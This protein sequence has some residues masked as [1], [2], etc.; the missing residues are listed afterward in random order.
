MR[1]EPEHLARAFLTDI[2]N[3]ADRAV[4][5]GRPIKQEFPAQSR[6]LSK[7][8]GQLTTHG[9][10]NS[11]FI[12]LRLAARENAVALHWID[13]SIGHLGHVELLDACGLARHLG[14]ERYESVVAR[15][16]VVLQDVASHP[17]VAELLAAWPARSNPGR[18]T[19][20]RAQDVRDALRVIEAASCLTDDIP[21]R[22]LSCQL[23]HDSKRVEA[24][25]N[26]V[27][28]LADSDPDA[29]VDEVL[30]QLGIIQFPQPLLIAGPCTITTRTGEQLRPQPYLGLAPTAL[31]SVETIGGYLL[32]VENLTTFNELAA[33]L[34]GP[35]RG[36]VLY[37]NGQPGSGL[38]SALQSVFSEATVPIYHWGDQDLGGFRILERLQRV[39]EASGRQV[40]PWMMDQPANE[41]RKAL[42]ES[43]I[44]K[45]NA[46]CERRGWL[47]CRLTPPA[48]A[49]E[50]ES[51]ELRQPP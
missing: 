4:A 33:G 35:L 13:E 14:A 46:I 27:R 5:R 22:R 3:A 24:L 10:L 18:L 28:W 47:S 31:L 7:Y 34:A 32:T 21:R 25:G 6:P 41:G 40:T 50:Q 45:I 51:M 15:A 26:V 39:A 16:A 8:L 36:T 29:D 48:M 42:S 23:F 44:H 30:S 37:V 38:A 1:T 43:D 12:V 2:L 17:K 20:D 9:A 49:R 19:P 11:F